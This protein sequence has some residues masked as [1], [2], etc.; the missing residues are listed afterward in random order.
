[1]AFT[2]T[3]RIDRIDRHRDRGQ[4]A[5]IAAM[6]QRVGVEAGEFRQDVAVELLR[7]MVE[8]GVVE[9]AAQMLVAR[10]RAE[11]PDALV[12]I[13]FPDFNFRLL[14][15][16]KRLGVPIAYYVSPQLWAWRAGRLNVIRQFVD[17]MLVIFPFEAAYKDTSG[18]TYDKVDI[19]GAKALL[20]KAQVTVVVRTDV[21]GVE[22][23]RVPARGDVLYGRR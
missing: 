2:L 6:G 22:S 13:D 12:V 15:V 17:R 16:M 10:A 11:R 14:P 20:E 4:A 9:A 19:A 23:R 1:M 21:G 7:R 8:A 3:G 18:G 5:A